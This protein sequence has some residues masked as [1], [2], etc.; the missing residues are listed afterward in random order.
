MKTITYF[1]V[2]IVAWGIAAF[3]MVH[4]TRG[5]SLGTILVCNLVGY[6]IAIAAIARDVNLGCTWN[7]FLAVSVAVLFVAAN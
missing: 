2:C 5:L 4:I 1:L 3:L 6:C 7:H